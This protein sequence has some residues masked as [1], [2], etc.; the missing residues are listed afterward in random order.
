MLE[1]FSDRAR[2]VVVLA[3]EEARRRQHNTVGPA[4]LLMG[5]L[6]DGE[7][8]GVALL[9]QF[10]VERAALA[11]ATARVL[12]AIPTAPG[13][14]VRLSEDAKDVLEAAL[15]FDA[16]HCRRFV[17]TEH[18][19]AALLADEDAPAFS[20]LLG[21]GAD[22]NRARRLLGMGRRMFARASDDS[23][24]LIATSKWRVRL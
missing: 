6:R 17:G 4:H 5:I 19:V 14:E 24:Q 10:G 1:R 16:Q 2:R 18:L 11:A 13:G 7:G 22:I 15:A 20:V 21:A 3:T 12:D 23:V 8:V 9:D